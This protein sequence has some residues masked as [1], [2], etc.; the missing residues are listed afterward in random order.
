ML[1]IPRR[2]FLRSTAGAILALPTLESLVTAADSTGGKLGSS[3]KT[4]QRV[5]FFYVPNG[6]IREEFFPGEQKKPEQEYDGPHAHLSTRTLKPLDVIGKKVTLITGL[7]RTWKDSSDQHE[8]CGSCFLSDLAPR[9]MKENRIPQGRTLDHIVAEKLSTDAPFRTLE[10]NCNPNKDHK[11]SIH[12]DSISWY[13]PEHPAGAMRNPVQVYRRLFLTKKSAPGDRI[14]DLVVADAQSMSRQLGKADRHKLGEYLE[15]IRTIERQMDRLSAMH[16]ELEKLQLPEPSASHL[17][18]GEFVQLM[19]DLMVVAL[20]CGLTRVA[21]F[22]I[23]PERWDTPYRFEHISDKPLSHHGLS[24]GGWSEHLRMIDEF[25][26]S[27]FAAMAAK[28]DSIREPD[29][30]TLLDNTLFTFGAGLGSG[31]SHQYTRLPIVIAGS[32]GGCFKTGFHLECK[33]KT[34]LAN[35]WLTQANAVGHR[36]QRFAD[37]T[38]ELGELLTNS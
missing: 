11:E 29:G 8:Q 32:G 24:H 20:H 17:P 2:S 23:A 27:R 37:S 30:S 21:T 4:P 9:D 34:P 18:R 7:A 16:D 5:A 28:M 35:L 33:D 38:G 26:M 25:H 3:S 22:M 15:S 6:L 31:G 10:F 19:G 36:K 13:G 12:F 14:T 1:N